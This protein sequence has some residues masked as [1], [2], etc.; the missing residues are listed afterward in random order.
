LCNCS[1]PGYRLQSDG[2]T[3]LSELVILFV[4]LFGI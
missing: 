4:I 2:M 3:C 1:G